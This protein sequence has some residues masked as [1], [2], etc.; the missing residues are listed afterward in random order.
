MFRRTTAALLVTS[1][2]GFSQL[3]CLGQGALGGKVLKFN[4]GVT[5][6]KW[7]RWL[8]FLLL[9]IIPVYPIAGLI[10][11]VIIN[12]I[13]FHTGTNPITDK[14]RLAIREGQE[15]IIAPDGSRAASTLNEDGSVTIEMTDAEGAGYTVHLVPVPG[16]IEARD[17]D[18][19]YLGSVDAN[20]QLHTA[21]GTV[22]LIP[23]S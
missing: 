16:G 6:N 22:P 4:L 14:P 2:L 8:V 12:S 10:D 5:E 11:L 3:G 15:E 13:E 23:G 18:G 17:G 9:N 21:N 20:G 1:M 19:T 7:G